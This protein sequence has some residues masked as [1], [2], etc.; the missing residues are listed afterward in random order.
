VVEPEAYF[1]DEQPLAPTETG[2]S[3][4]LTL[5][6]RALGRLRLSPQ[7]AAALAP[8]DVEVGLRHG[9]AR[10]RRL[11]ERD[12][13]T[14]YGI[15]YP[16]DCH[17]GIVLSCNVESG[18]SVVRIRT[19]PIAP[20]ITTSDGNSYDYQ[21]NV[22]VYEREMG[23]KELPPT[24][25]SAAANLTE[26]INRALRLRGRKCEDGALALTLGELATVILGATWQPGDSIPIA[27]ALETMGLE[28]SGTDYLWRSRITRRTRSSDRSLLV[29]YGEAQPRGRLARAVHRHW[30]PMHLRRYDEYSG[31]SP[32]AS[33]RATYAEARRRFGMYGVLP[34]ELPE[35]CTWVEPYSWSADEEEPTVSQ[36][37]LLELGESET[38][39]QPFVLEML[40]ESRSE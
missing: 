16:W 37:E 17:P 29:A 40:T 8:G 5:R 27:V 26:L 14:L 22:G 34:E 25:K 9:E 3:V 7:A 2:F 35:G 39:A 1:A 18:G 20:S 19:L 12:G 23:L 32:S 15:E 10:E 30:V 28:R 4:P 24:E 13:L 31:R 21:T 6:D 11:V 33:K 38:G 36:L